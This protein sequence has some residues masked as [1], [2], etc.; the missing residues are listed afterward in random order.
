MKHSHDNTQWSYDN[1]AVQ[2]KELKAILELAGNGISLIDKR[3]SFLYSNDSFQQMIGYTMEEL[4]NHTCVSLAI[5]EYRKPSQDAI[6]YAVKHGMIQN[7][8]KICETRDGRLIYAHMSLSYIKERDILV[9]VSADI[10][11]EHE[12][13]VK[14][15]QEVKEKVEAFR[16]QTEVIQQ[17]NK[18]AAMGEMVS[19]IAHQ[20][21]QPLNTLGIIAQSLKHQIRNR[22]YDEN[23]LLDIQESMME[24]I[25]F[26]S[27]TIDDF[28]HFFT[29]STDHTL[30]SIHES[31]REAVSLV[32]P[33]YINSDISLEIDKCDC[34]VKVFG[35]QNEF[36]HV[37][38]N[39]LSNAQKAI[40]KNHVKGYV[41][42]EVSCNENTTE[43]SISD[44]GGGIP[45]QKLETIF[46]PYV[47][48]DGGTG[49]GLYMSK[50]IIEEHMKGKIHASNKGAGAC[51]HI[52]FNM[53]DHEQHL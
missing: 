51:F 9:M 48:Q 28:Y 22:C 38:L 23:S 43:I 20:W 52:S 53:K 45:E 25:S 21:R 44:N 4:K 30:F 35:R 39:L 3:G 33:A 2:S 5:P 12:Y 42:I 34:S 29:P 50:I 18:M 13:T 8:K 17:R 1:L 41:R 14:L 46:E 37:I 7:F 32:S 27:Q 31:I 26:L 49:I 19:A 36:K 16:K 47:S 15:E 24:K 11:D 10:S 6:D 40:Q